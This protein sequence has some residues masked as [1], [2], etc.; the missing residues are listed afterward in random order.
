[1][2]V[3][4]YFL[5]VLGNNDAQLTRESKRVHVHIFKYC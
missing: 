1:M 3:C 2:C 5:I 4:I